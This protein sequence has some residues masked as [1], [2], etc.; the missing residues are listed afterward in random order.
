MKLLY[1]ADADKMK[2]ALELITFNALAVVSP[3]T[4]ASLVHVQLQNKLFADWLQ[5]QQH[6]RSEGRS[7]HI[8]GIRASAHSPSATL[9]RYSVTQ[10]SLTAINPRNHADLHTFLTSKYALVLTLI[11]I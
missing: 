1:L 5:M 11:W 6:L 9:A 8:L 7:N 10:S 4:L 2:A 3:P